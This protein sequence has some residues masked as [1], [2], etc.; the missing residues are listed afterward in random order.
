MREWQPVAERDP[1]QV[2][3]ARAAVREITEALRGPIAAV[4]DDSDPQ[5]VRQ[6]ARA[7]A[8]NHD[9]L[10]DTRLAIDKVS[11]AFARARDLHDARTAVQA[12]TGRRHEVLMHHAQ[13]SSF[14]KRGKARK[15]L[16]EYAP[17][18]AGL[19]HDR[20]ESWAGFWD[21]WQQLRDDCEALGGELRLD[22]PEAYDPTVITAY[23]SRL[24]RA[25]AVAEAIEAARATARERVRLRLPLEPLIADLHQQKMDR[26]TDRWECAL[27]ALGADRSGNQQLEDDKA[28]EWLASRP[29]ELDDAIDSERYDDAQQILDDLQ[30]RLSALPDLAERAQILE[31]PAATLAE[32][33]KAL[34]AAAAAGESAPSFL[35]DLEIALAAQPKVHRLR[36]IRE[37]KTTREL[38]DELRG[39]REAALA[40]AKQLLSLR[41]Q[42]RIYEGFRS[43]RFTASLEHFRKAISTSAKRFDRLEEIKNSS[44]FDVS[45]LTEVFPCWIMRPED[46]C[47]MFPLCHDIFDVVIFDEA[48]QCNPDQTLPILARSKVSV[49][50]GDDNQLS[51]E[52]LKRSLAGN[53][54]KALLTQ[55]KLAEL[56]PEGLFDQTENSLLGLVSTRDQAPIVL[57]EHFRCRPELVAFSNARFYADGLRVMRDG[58]DDRGLGPA[59]QVHE[60]KSVPPLGKSKVNQYEG[61]LLV[62]ELV[63]LL[64]DPRYSGLS[65]G[66]LSLFREQIEYIESLVER[67]VP[68]PERDSRRLICS[69]VDGFQGDERDVILYSWR[70]SPTQSP[71]I[72]AF[73]NGKTGDQRVNVALTRARHQAIHFISAPI[74]RFPATGNVGQFMRHADQPERLV[75]AIEGL[76]HKESITEAR[77]RVARALDKSGLRCLEQFIACGVGVDLVVHDPTDW[78]RAA[79]F[80][81]GELDPAPPPT[82]DRRVDAH[83]LLE[84]AGW[85]VERILAEEAI[86]QPQ[87]VLDRVSAALRR[88]G[89]RERPKID[90]KRYTSWDVTPEPED[91]IQAVGVSETSASIASEDYADYLWPA[92]S[93]EARLAAGEDVFQSDFE[94]QLYDRLAQFEDLQVVPQWR[95]RGKFIDLVVTDRDGRRLAIEADGEQHHET[96]GG[97]LIPEDVYRQKLLE[98]VGWVFHRVRFTE[99][100]RDP[101]RHINEIRQHLARQPGN[102]V[103]AAQ[104]RD[105]NAVSLDELEQ[106]V[107]PAASTLEVD[108]TG[109]AA[110]TGQSRRSSTG[111]LDKPLAISGEVGSEDHSADTFDE[112][113]TPPS[114][115]QPTETGLERMETVAV[116]APRADGKV[117]MRSSAKSLEPD[118]YRGC[119][120][121]H[122]PL[123]LLPQQIAIVVNERGGVPDD[124]IVKEFAE[125]FEI[126]T[127]SKRH[128]LLKSFAWSASGRKFI[129]KAGDRW[130]PGEADPHPIE[131][132]DTWTM[133]EIEQ[134]VRSLREHGVASEALFD[135]ALEHVWETDHRV[136]KPLTKA[137]GSAVYAVVGKRV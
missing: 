121:D 32:G 123:A 114:H 17:G 103:L 60:I 33:I 62:E 109:S 132:L 85:T 63:R 13:L 53:A 28:L 36:A 59:I 86:S 2:D 131:H 125:H 10:D 67:Q 47:R 16:D 130:L 40:D 113:L 88:C 14:M 129:Y 108:K 93:V 39:L 134:L 75:Q 96:I 15:W 58:E 37:G 110:D 22:V 90:A 76:A 101:E 12:A 79:V 55:S 21:A 104:A 50:F 34:E 126:T 100:S 74:E 72:L 8:T 87:L 64:A 127:P 120:F 41:I 78:A 82:A 133:A 46:A 137:I 119:D 48:S 92:P 6:F 135:Q 35:P 29:H 70:Y 52:D 91:E 9:L 4:E 77:R 112:P 71:S 111:V 115:D 102:V 116:P 128:R 42:Q 20:V 11:V 73:T 23:I 81:D 44:D 3:I 19:D 26:D 38:A 5:R 99:F 51:N 1:D 7:L 54:N 136:P 106:L 97:D 117:L 27:V 31:G 57:N 95:S 24:R 83:G 84:R 30:A 69:T 56:D 43:P 105:E 61:Q 80:I 89:P 68:K 45:V 49:V 18:S 25:L 94:R 124:E 65:I 66:C 107:E 98:E 118:S 122:V